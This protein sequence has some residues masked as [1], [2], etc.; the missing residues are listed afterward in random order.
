MHQPYF[1]NV[2]AKHI[3]SKNW[4]EERKFSN[5]VSHKADLYAVTLILAMA[6]KIEVHFRYGR[7]EKA[8]YLWQFFS[9]HSDITKDFWEMR[10]AYFFPKVKDCP[11]MVPKMS[12]G[13]TLRTVRSSRI[14]TRL[15]MYSYFARHDGH[16]QTV[17][18][19]LPCACLFYP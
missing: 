11:L 19:L 4:E 17:L 6:S 10:Y 16:P 8:C 14:G 12:L 2:I 1:D 18:R 13:C 7:N 9:E 3:L 15:N 5:E